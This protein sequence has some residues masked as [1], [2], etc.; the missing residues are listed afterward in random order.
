MS[1]A[2]H[3]SLVDTN[4]TRIA[5]ERMSQRLVTAFVLSGIFFMLLPGTFLGVWNLLSISQAHDVA[6]LPQAWLQAHGQAQLF[7]WIGSFIL[8]IGFYSLTKMQSGQPFPARPGWTAWFLWT[9]GVSLRWLAGVTTWNWRVGL[10]LSAVLQLAAFLLFYVSVRRHRPQTLTKPE[11]WMRI[12]AAAT[13]GFLVTLAVNCGLLIRQAWTGESPALPHVLDQQFVVLAVWG[14]LIPTIWG[15]NARWLPVFAGLKKPDS[16][17]LLLAY[18]FSIIGVVTTIASWL[19]VA[20]VALL[21]AALLSIDALHV[22]ES[23]VNPP[24]LLNIH[25]T[26]AIFIRL[27]YGWLLLSCLLAL[28]AISLDRSGGLWGASRHA[29]TVGFVAGMVLTIGQRILP[30]FCGM[31]VLWSK[32]LMFWSLLL[33]Y[34]GCSLRVAS[35]PLAYER[36]WAP[37]WK[38]LPYSAVMELAAVSLFALNIGVTLYRAPAHLHLQTKLFPSQG[39]A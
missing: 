32:R 7:G 34:G 6:T 30:A 20:G 8:G 38:V 22:W 33:L 5:G 28:L 39:A 9:L 15:F 13:V 1:T 25:P 23:S 10:P 14:I 24:K 27:T 31:R 4:A 26:F 21:F 2:P 17:R 35:E 12:V 29:L 18:A 37:A 3:L 16:R 36:L 11:V 19:S